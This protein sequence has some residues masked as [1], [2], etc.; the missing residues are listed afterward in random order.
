M[1]KLGDIDQTREIAQVRALVVKFDQSVVLRIVSFAKRLQS[2]VITSNW[3][4]SVSKELRRRKFVLI[5]TRVEGAKHACNEFIYAIALMDEGHKSRDSAFVV[6]NVAKVRKDEL[7][8]LLNLIL[9]YHEICDGLVAFVGVIDGLETDVFLV[10]ECSV[11]F[12]VG[13]VEREFGEQEV[14]VFSDQRTIAADTF[15]GHAAIQAV[16]PAPVG[17]GFLKGTRVAFLQDL[18]YGN[19]SFESLDLVGHDGLSVQSFQSAS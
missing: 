15:T 5:L 16:D 7:L 14:D 19:E 9:Q 2:I 3:G 1:R 8:E 10:F 18:V 12:G 6:T 11:E 17:H 13:L 4:K